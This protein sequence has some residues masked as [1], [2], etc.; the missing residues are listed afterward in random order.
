M[1]GGTGEHIGAGAEEHEHNQS[2]RLG[3]RSSE[4]VNEKGKIVGGD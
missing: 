3:E 2:Q 4:I 1:L